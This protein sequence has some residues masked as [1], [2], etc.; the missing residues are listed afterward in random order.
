MRRRKAVLVT[1]SLAFS[2]FGAACN[3]RSDESITTDIK[4]KTFSEPLL[5]SVSVNVTSKDGI[6][7]SPAR[8]PTTPRVSLHS[9]SPRKRKASSR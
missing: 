1:L 4:A 6:V 8:F 9:A 5:K 2:L 7:T 3:H